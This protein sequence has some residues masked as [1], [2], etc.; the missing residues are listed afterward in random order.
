MV[1]YVLNRLI[2]KVLFVY[3]LDLAISLLWVR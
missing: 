2:D 3:V 1:R